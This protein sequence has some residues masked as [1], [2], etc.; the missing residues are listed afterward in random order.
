MGRK[1]T[2]RD[3]RAHVGGHSPDVTDG[4]KVTSCG[5]DYKRLESDNYC[6]SWSQFW[7]EGLRANSYAIQIAVT[8]E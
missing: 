3:L 2:F 6:S 7:G 4:I 5:G 1:R 8:P